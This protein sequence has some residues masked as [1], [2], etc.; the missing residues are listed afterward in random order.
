MR[1]GPK[2]NEFAK[3][4]Y[5]TAC[6]VDC[7]RLNN[8]NKFEDANKKGILMPIL[9][10][11]RAILKKK[12]FK[13]VFFCHFFLQTKKFPSRFINKHF[14]CNKKNS[15]FL[16][17]RFNMIVRPGLYIHERA[18]NSESLY[19]GIYQTPTADGQAGVCL[20]SRSTDLKG[21]SYYRD[22]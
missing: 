20:P 21:I 14:I 7:D 17:L 15:R 8:K 9:L 3:V 11:V 10:K 18:Q 19:Y 5:R 2:K 13:I 22:Y 1:Q 16:P 6:S 4:K 12:E